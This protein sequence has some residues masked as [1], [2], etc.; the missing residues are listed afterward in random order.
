MKPKCLT[1]VLNF[2][3]II[4]MALKTWTA[5]ADFCES[6]GDFDGILIGSDELKLH[7]KTEWQSK[8][9][10]GA[11][12][13]TEEWIGDATKYVVRGQWRT[14]FDG[15]EAG[16]GW[17]TLSWSATEP[18]SSDV[19]FRARSAATETGLASATWTG[20]YATTPVDNEAGDNRW[21]QLEAVLI[22]GSSPSVQDISQYY[23]AGC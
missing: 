8:T 1:H 22:E 17:G 23:G 21:L 7:L 6:E 9:W 13:E 3:K 10:L 2:G 11:A 18:D 20:F 15:G 12:D 19:Q 5:D 14:N 4:S 16:C